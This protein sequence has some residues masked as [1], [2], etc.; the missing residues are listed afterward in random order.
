MFSRTKDT[1]VLSFKDHL[2]VTQIIITD[3]NRSNSEAAW[4]IG[5]LRCYGDREYNTLHLLSLNCMSIRCLLSLFCFPFSVFR[6]PFSALQ[7]WK[8]STSPLLFYA[9]WKQTSH[10][11]GFSVSQ[12]TTGMRSHFL[13]KLLTS[14][15]LPSMRNSAL[16]FPSFLKPLLYLESS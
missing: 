8:L 4:R 2:P 7:Y 13:L 14:T 16:T 15:F 6:F 11:E 1:G 3:T 12:D 9:H 10:V 5:P